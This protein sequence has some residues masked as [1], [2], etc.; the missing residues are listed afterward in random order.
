MFFEKKTTLLEQNDEF[1]GGILIREDSEW[2]KYKIQSL[3]EDIKSDVT[4]RVVTN[5]FS[6]IKSKALSV[7]FAIVDKSKGDITRL[8]NYNTISNAISFIKKGVSGQSDDAQIVKAVSQLEFTLNTLIKYKK[9]FQ[10]GFML[11]DSI[12]RYLYN[13]I[14]IAIIQGTSYLVSETVQLT[15][16]NLNLY[17][18]TYRDSKEIFNNNHIKSIS[19]FNQ[20]ER[21]GQLVKLFKESHNLAENTLINIGK[22]VLKRLSDLGGVTKWIAILGLIGFSLTFIRSI[23]FLYF[24]SRVKLS[25]YLTHLKDFVEMNSSTLEHDAKKVRERQEKIAQA[26]GKLSDRIRVDQNVANDRAN[27]QIEES[28]KIIAIDNSPS[29]NSTSL[30]LY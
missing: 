22:D 18:V 17:N 12:T 26:L 1:L 8:A 27:S 16:D 21:K 10:R 11:N 19:V 15:K 20:L 13:S 25:Q 30:D 28:N 29:N 6:D 7:D 23:I 4:D 9:D 2:S 5:L 14:V 24:N 3:A